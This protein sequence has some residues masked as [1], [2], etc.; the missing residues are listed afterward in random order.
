L[1]RTIFDRQETVVLWSACIWLNLAYS[2]DEEVY[3]LHLRERKLLLAS[4]RWRNKG[5]RHSW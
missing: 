4:I 2:V 5:C 3:L 1:N